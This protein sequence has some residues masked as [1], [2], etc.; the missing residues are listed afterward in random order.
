M[1]VVPGACS[2]K[3]KGI[4]RS[5]TSSNSPDHVGPVGFGKDF[6]FSLS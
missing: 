4:E 3:K 6:G 2:K 1:V 5:Q